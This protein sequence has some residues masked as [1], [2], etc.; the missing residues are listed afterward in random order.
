MK[1]SKTALTKTDII[2][3]LIEYKNI[4]SDKVSD[5]VAAANSTIK[6]GFAYYPSYY[7]FKDIAGK[8]YVLEDAYSY[9]NEQTAVY[10]IVLDRDDNDKDVLRAV[11]SKTSESWSEDVNEAHSLYRLPNEVKHAS[12]DAEG[13]KV[14]IK[15]QCHKDDSN[16]P[17]DSYAKNTDGEK[18]V[19]ATI[20]D[21]KKWIEAAQKARCHLAGNEI[22]APIYTIV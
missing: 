2:D 21:A 6:S 13:V 12:D 22:A 3:L 5:L 17:L 16:A 20:G 14:W 8:H 10:E 4:E 15:Y 19:F 11:F 7:F 9:S 1:I 18:E